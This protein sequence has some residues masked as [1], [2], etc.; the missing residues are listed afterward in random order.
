MLAHGVDHQRG[1]PLEQLDDVGERLVGRGEAER[2][3]GG[4]VE[5]R[6]QIVLGLD[7]CLEPR[8]AVALE[9]RLELL[10]EGPGRR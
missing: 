4:G 10:G 6:E 9:G 3:V 8:L 7:A 5:G 1:A 2:S